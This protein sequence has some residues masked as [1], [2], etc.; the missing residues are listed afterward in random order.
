M[1]DFSL[2]GKHMKQLQGGEIGFHLEF[3][4]MI[5]SAVASDPRLNFITGALENM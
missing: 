5:V 4:P 3:Q 1:P 2:I